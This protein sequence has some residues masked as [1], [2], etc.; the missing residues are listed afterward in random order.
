MIGHSD[1]ERELLDEERVLEEVARQLEAGAELATW[2]EELRTALALGLAELTMSRTEGW[3]AVV[4]RR[5]LFGPESG[6]PDC[7]GVPAEPSVPERRRAERLRADLP[8]RVRYR[9]GMY[10]IAAQ[11]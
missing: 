4:L 2:P 3:K 5:H 1:I 8:T 7:L 10:L 11:R 9:G 6:V